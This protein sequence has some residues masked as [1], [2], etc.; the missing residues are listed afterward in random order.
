VLATGSKAGLIFAIGVPA[1]LALIAVARAKQASPVRLFVTILALTGAAIVLTLPFSQTLLE[2]YR[3]ETVATLGTRDELWGYAVQLI[4]QH[5]FTGLGFGGW[6]KLFALQAFLTGTG[7][8]PAHNSLLILW[9]Q[10]GVPGLIAGLVLIATVYATAARVLSAATDPTR[11]IAM[12]IAG[13]FTWYV[14]QGLGENFGLVGEVHMT[15][16]LGALLGYA[17][18]TYDGHEVETQNASEPVCGDSAPPALP[19]V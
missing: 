13:S 12:A 9:L 14:G 10:S 2:T 4:R 11:C 16:M 3:Y 17:C 7:V 18:A 1:V 6:E 15:P 5:A 19:A 8:M